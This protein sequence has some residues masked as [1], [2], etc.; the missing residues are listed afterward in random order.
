MAIRARP[1]IST[2]TE[3]DELRGSLSDLTGCRSPCT[4][5]EDERVFK[6]YSQMKLQR[7]RE[8]LV[9][10]KRMAKRAELGRS[11]SYDTARANCEF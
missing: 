6:K 5:V 9:K 3:H 2:A 8:A 1:S 4:A 10:L 11:P 7:K